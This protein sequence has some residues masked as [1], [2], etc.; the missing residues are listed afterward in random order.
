MRWNL[1]ESQWFCPQCLRPLVV[2]SEGEELFCPGE[3]CDYVGTTAD[4]V[5][6]V[7]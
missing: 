1:G 7:A 6:V 3:D 4:A 2:A 5:P